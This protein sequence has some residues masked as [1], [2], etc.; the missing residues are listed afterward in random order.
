MR[1]AVALSRLVVVA[2][3][4]GEIIQ[5]GHP[6]QWIRIRYRIAGVSAVPVHRQLV[7][8]RL[9]RETERWVFSRVPQTADTLDLTRILRYYVFATND[10]SIVSKRQ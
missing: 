7:L 5:L 1:G 4:G 10:I 9:V 3:D 2:V 6:R 8:S